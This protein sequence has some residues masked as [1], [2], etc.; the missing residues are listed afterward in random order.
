METEIDEKITICPRSSQ[1]SRPGSA[2][3]KPGPK[4]NPFGNAKPREVILQEKGRDWRKIDLDLEHRRIDRYYAV[5]PYMYPPSVLVFHLSTLKALFG[6]KV[7]LKYL[8]NTTACQNI[9]FK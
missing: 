5:C 6:S 2:S 9:S 1:F 4:V 8:S 3:L 7:F